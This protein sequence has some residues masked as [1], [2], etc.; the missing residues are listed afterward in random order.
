V[1]VLRKRLNSCR[2][3]INQLSLRAVNSMRLG[4]SGRGSNL[5]TVESHSHCIIL[6]K[7][8]VNLGNYP[9]GFAMIF[10]SPSR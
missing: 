9:D 6:D 10:L 8:P 7:Y 3:Q 2:R 4:K 1:K 5:V